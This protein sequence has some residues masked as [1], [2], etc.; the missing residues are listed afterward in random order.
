M[1]N[2]TIPLGGTSISH[3]ILL[4]QRIDSAGYHEDP[5]NVFSR[6]HEPDNVSLCPSCRTTLGSPPVVEELDR[7]A[8]DFKL[9]PTVRDLVISS[10]NGCAMCRLV[11]YMLLFAREGYYRPLLLGSIGTPL[12]ITF[13]AYRT[14]WNWD[15]L[16][17]SLGSYKGQSENLVAFTEDGR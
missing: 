12:K 11:Y 13:A 2:T 9:T 5:N 14:R 8:L 10:Y 4:D 17:F 1:T 6:H 7:F 16:R 3:E 15:S